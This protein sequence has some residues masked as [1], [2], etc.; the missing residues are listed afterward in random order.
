[1]PKNIQ[2]FTVRGDARQRVRSVRFALLVICRFR[3]NLENRDGEE[4]LFPC[5]PM[6]LVLL[7]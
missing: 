1:M 7:Q 3:K 6:P 5:A 4:E 2:P